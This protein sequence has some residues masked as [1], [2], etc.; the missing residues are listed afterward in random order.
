MDAPDR[1][2]WAK[3]LARCTARARPRMPCRRFRL[4]RAG[5]G[6]RIANRVS[7]GAVRIKVTGMGFRK[8]CLQTL[9]GACRR[10]GAGLRCRVPEATRLLGSGNHSVAMTGWKCGRRGEGRG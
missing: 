6:A 3:G 9:S 10:E 8:K 7:G 1:I 5:L 4:A 2:N